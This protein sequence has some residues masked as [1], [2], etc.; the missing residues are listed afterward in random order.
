MINIKTASEIKQG[1]VN[2]Y[3]KVQ[4]KITDL[5]PV[6]I[7]GGIFYGV[8][9]ELESIYNELQEVEK[10]S[11]VATAE[12][13]YLD[14]H[15]EGTYNLQR[16]DETRS[17]GYVVVYSNSRIQDPDSLT[18]KCAYE[19]ANGNLVDVD[20][21]EKFVTS[22]NE[23]ESG[24]VFALVK[25][26]NEQYSKIITDSS[27][28]KY[29]TVNL[30]GKY[31]QFFL[32]PVVSLT[33]GSANN[34]KEGSITIYPSPPTGVSGVVNTYD[35]QTYF[36]ASPDSYNVPFSIRYTA[37][38]AYDEAK[39]VFSVNNAYYFSDRGGMVEFEDLKGTKIMGLYYKKL[40]T[41][42]Y[43]DLS[44]PVLRNLRL[45]YDEAQLGTLKLVDTIGNSSNRSDSID[46]LPSIFVKN[47]EGLD[48]EYKLL[49]VSYGDTKV[50]WI[51]DGSPYL[52][53]PAKG[54]SDF[55]KARI[56][57]TLNR[58]LVVRQV[59]VA[60]DREIVFDPDNILA[61]DGTIKDNA[62]IGG[63]TDKE[64]DE[65]YRNKLKKY[66]SSLP[67][68]TRSA[69]EAGALTVDGV[70]FAKTIT[71][72]SVPRGSV[73]LLVNS[74][75]GIVGGKTLS[76]VRNVLEKDWKAAGVNLIIKTPELVEISVVMSLTINSE[77][78]EDA[79][80]EQV[81]IE[82]SN[83]FGSKTPGSSLSYSEI[84]SIIQAIPG[85]LNV[86]SVFFGKKLT[87]QFYYNNKAYVVLD[88]TSDAQLANT[89]TGYDVEVL[90]KLLLN[91]EFNSPSVNEKITFGLNVNNPDTYYRK[92]RVSEN[93][94]LE[95]INNV[96]WDTIAE[97]LLSSTTAQDY[98][99]IISQYKDDI[100][101]SE[102][103][104]TYNLEY[105][106]T[107]FVSE[108]LSLKYGASAK[109]IPVEVEELQL[110]VLEEYDFDTFQIPVDASMSYDKSVLQLVGTRFIK[111]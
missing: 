2:F 85:V 108:P 102:S 26:Q 11:F 93:G 92:C 9:V 48:E 86:W 97:L 50:N 3:T 101:Y 103:N 94:T 34:V 87:T 37:S 57:D 99:D 75:S 81:K 60:L 15:I 16:N 25:P 83:Y 73:V 7:I 51:Y 21:A 54:L 71:G 55:F 31:A 58:G 70:T 84:I 24:K 82:V 105:E 35:P 36:F 96:K 104:D 63:A 95:R 12:G 27:G 18:L 100:F 13:Q 109:H 77:Y 76:E 66:L 29:Y 90:K 49:G 43:F 23:T 79:V 4:D 19:D 106:V 14:R 45:E 59:Q 33:E 30:K 38:S 78:S 98:I 1:I 56:S 42:P 64:G 69:L 62:R 68:A 52:N 39:G 32:L 41:E 44:N 8:S 111:E 74:T 28:R 65:A 72:V 91:P 67:R 89:S 22:G 17:Y 107:R 5:G 6:S 40:V 47:A 53:S 80:N 20:I 110:R 46:E 61:D 10:Q 88:S